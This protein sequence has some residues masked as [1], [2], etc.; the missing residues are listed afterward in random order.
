MTETDALSLQMSR[1]TA[2]LVAITQTNHELRTELNQMAVST[3]Q[4]ECERDAL[5][6]RLSDLESRR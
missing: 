6:I 1:I 2:A 4:L 3:H 5:T